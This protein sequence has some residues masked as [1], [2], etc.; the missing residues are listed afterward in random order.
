MLLPT[1]TQNMLV[2][3]SNSQLPSDISQAPFVHFR[4]LY[5][6]TKG[7]KPT[8]FEYES[9]SPLFPLTD[10]PPRKMVSYMAFLISSNVEI[11]HQNEVT[12]RY[13]YFTSCIQL[14]TFSEA[15]LSY[16]YATPI[17]CL[18]HLSRLYIRP[19]FWGTRHSYARSCVPQHCNLV[20]VSFH[21][22]SFYFHCLISMMQR[23]GGILA[24]DT[25]W[26]SVSWDRYCMLKYLIH[27]TL[28]S[29][30]RLHHSIRNT[31]LGIM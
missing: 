12:S 2:D 7:H 19:S 8:L 23:I 17:S 4:I 10:G 25:H 22:H 14:L 16:S 15:F 5:N 24:R 6:S 9:S 30:R 1:E 13:I 31:I 27:P 3:Y 28:N 29:L 18:L 20:C 26:S 11:L 21:I